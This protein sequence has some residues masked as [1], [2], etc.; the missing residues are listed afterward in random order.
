MLVVRPLMHMFICLQKH[1]PI[2]QPR[3]KISTIINVNTYIKKHLLKSIYVVDRLDAH[4][5]RDATIQR[6]P[7]LV[8]LQL[9][10]ILDIQ[11]KLQTTTLLGIDPCCRLNT[12]LNMPINL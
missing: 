8:L 10:T 1:T 11:E 6:R 3:G 4:K 5:Q 2:T 9:H 7:K 12:L